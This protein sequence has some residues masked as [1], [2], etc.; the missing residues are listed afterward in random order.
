MVRLTS[1]ISINEV[2]I[3]F[4]INASC[5]QRGHTG[6]RKKRSKR[7]EKEEKE[8][9]EEE[10]EEEEEQEEQGERES[11]IEMTTVLF[12]HRLRYPHHCVKVYT[13]IC[14]TD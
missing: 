6:R 2:S 8:E 4:N 12:R 5:T 7:K 3:S 11:T 1:H 10:D 9:E 14:A 13:G